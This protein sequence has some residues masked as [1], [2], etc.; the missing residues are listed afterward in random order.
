MTVRRSHTP[1]TSSRPVTTWNSRTCC[2]LR[3]RNGHVHR[4]LHLSRTITAPTPRPCPHP[5]TS[6]PLGAGYTICTRLIRL[7]PKEFK[8]ELVSVAARASV[9]WPSVPK[10]QKVAIALARS[11]FFFI[12]PV[13]L[14]LGICPRYF[15]PRRPFTLQSHHATWIPRDR[16][17]RKTV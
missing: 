10:T 9:S 14:K 3:R 17:K 7:N 13:V 5:Q 12:S 6:L 16:Q 15:H 11:Q 1:P 8:N 4:L 2:I